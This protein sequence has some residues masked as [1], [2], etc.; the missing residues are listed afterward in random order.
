MQAFGSGRTSNL[1][2][3]PIPDPVQVPLWIDIS[4]VV[5]A[6]LGGSVVAVRAGFDLTGIFGLGILTGLGGGLIRDVL[7]N[8]LPV[9]MR[10][11]WY[12]VAAISA[13]ATVSLIAKQ[14]EKR[15]ALLIILDAGALGLYGVTGTNKALANGLGVWPALL[16]GVIA[17]TG[18]GVL[19]D[20]MTQ[21]KPAIFVKGGELYATACL[22]GLVSYIA[23]WKL[24]ANGPEIAAAAAALTFA[25][26]MVSWRFQIHLPGAVDA[27]TRIKQRFSSTPSDE[28]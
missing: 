2:P 11:P 14:V 4:A 19:R 5:V 13:A 28:D 26:R 27:P 21:Q 12:I 16:L 18:G 22:A 20:I 9:A 15:L 25:I 8:E 6:A 23:A 10:S 7:L 3:V 17:G 1:G 24:G